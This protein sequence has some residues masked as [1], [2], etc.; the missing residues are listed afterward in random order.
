M[1]YE[2]SFS[3]G[4][5]RKEITA[6]DSLAGREVVCPGCGA[7]A[8]VPIPGL[9]GGL[10]LGEFVL[11][12]KIGS[13]GMGEVWLSEQKT[14]GRKVA[15][16][17]LHPRLVVNERFI[18]RF[19]AEATMS[20]KLEHPNIVMA[21]SAGQVG[22][23]YYL[24]TSYVDGVELN[25][26]LKTD[27]R[28]PEREALKIAKSVAEALRYAWNTHRMIHRD[29]KPANIMIDV[30]GNLR[31]MDFGISK[32]IDTERGLNGGDDL[33]GTPEYIS[34]EQVR[35]E[36]GIDFH[37]DIYSLGI[38]LFQLIMGI[39]PFKGATVE[40]TLKMQLNAPF[41]RLDGLGSGMSLPCYKLIE[42]MT[43]KSPKDRHTSWDYVIA[44]IELVLE[45]RSPVGRIFNERGE[46]GK[47]AVSSP[48]APIRMNISQPLPAHVTAPAAKAAEAEIK[49]AAP[50]AEPPPRQ[51][52]PV[53]APPRI[54]FKKKK[55]KTL[56]Y[57]VIAILIMAAAAGILWMFFV[58]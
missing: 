24:A 14:L 23:F 28:I 15:L 58:R 10:E 49:A 47:V 18:H 2:I 17:I 9:S 19:L 46:P 38:T 41:P 50:V 7:T 53:V 29:I 5:C 36:D 1:A 8:T 43:A 42:I 33:C 4:K 27:R 35:A 3:C 25:N 54:Q 16:K 39:L 45:G 6:P 56:L 55:P 30:N 37:V 44:D 12:R 32:I 57:V 26:R 21:Y 13:G 31:L 40:E 48:R 51:V 22:D 34:P 20:G 52:A 11:I